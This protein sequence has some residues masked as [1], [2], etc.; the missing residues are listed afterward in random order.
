MYSPLDQASIKALPPVSI[1]GSLMLAV[2]TLL[3]LWLGVSPQPLMQLLMHGS[4]LVT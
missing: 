1:A 2:L 4:I 3:L